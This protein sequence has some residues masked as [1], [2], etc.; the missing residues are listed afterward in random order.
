MKHDT[1]GGTHLQNSD[2][3]TSRN[4]KTHLEQ[5]R[6]VIGYLQY[7][8][9]TYWTRSGLF[10]SANAIIFSIL[11]KMV[12]EVDSMKFHL[13]VFWVVFIGGLVGMGISALWINLNSSA[14]FWIN[15]W[16]TVLKNLE[17]QAFGNTELF[18]GVQNELSSIKSQFDILPM[19][20]ISKSSVYFCTCSIACYSTRD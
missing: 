13:A 2:D 9:Q 8:N 17:S 15:R 16:H 20:F 7:E 6:I 10:L 19:M 18:R 4:G 1:T 12:T 11:G 14:K 3:A 5:Y